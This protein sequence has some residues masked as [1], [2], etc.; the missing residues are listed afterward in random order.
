MR[1]ITCLVLS[2]VLALSLAACGSGSTAS[3]TAAAAASTGVEDGVL[4]IAMECAYAPYNWMQGDD[5]NGAVPISNV[6]GSYANGYDVMIGKKIAEANGWELEVI[7][8]DWDS[9]VPGVQTG[10]Y[11]AVIA[12]QSMTAER[13]EQVDFAGPYFYA[14]I[15]CVTKKDSPY[16]T[17]ASIADLA[18]GKCT[19]QIATIWYDQCLPQIDGALVQ[20][21]AETAPAMLM[22]LET[23]SVDFICTDMPTAQGAVAAY[24]DMTILDFSG[25]DGDFQFA[26]EEE[27]AENVNIGISVQ[28]GNTQLADAIDTV[29]SALNEEQFNALM[30]QAISIQPEI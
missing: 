16:A 3:T 6:P 11:D 12:G 15:V 27:R 28:K 22:A 14:S 20:T 30:D 25:T 13:S 21:A 5:S 23:G 26:T 2:L 9:L 19:A 4:T 7:Q 17:A 24:P 1:K 10:I 8:A 29:L 18:G